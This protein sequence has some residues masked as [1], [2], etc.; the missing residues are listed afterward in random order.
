MNRG[1]L[2]DL[3]AFAVV[4]RESSFTRAATELRLSTSALSY[5]IKKLETRLGLVLLRRNSRSVSATEAGEKL[6]RR[7]GPA[8]AEIAGALDDAGQQRD[9]V[10]GTVRITATR[11][12]FE[13]VLRPILPGFGESHPEAT[14][15]VLVEY[16]FR[17]IVADRFDAG[18]RLGE[19]VEKDMIAVS[20]SP[21]L[22]MAV[23]ASPDYLA[24]QLAPETPVELT[25]HR[26]IN[27][28]MMASG[29]L[30][31]W[32]FERD[33][34]ALDVKVD[35]PLTFNEPALMLEAAVDGLG[36]AYVL[37]DQA[38][39][40]IADGRLVRLL[41]DW[42]PAFPGYFLYYPSRHQ[43]PPVL[44]ALIPTLRRWRVRME[45]NGG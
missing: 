12:A 3:A 38:S 32:E 9:R 40:L 44:A 33:G 37:E 13:T 35:G 24:R 15:E 19:K 23:V 42:T 18:I 20:V 10:S 29:S 22:R 11:H 45:T 27:Y 7:L 26:C 30:Y 31:P 41:A 21:E 36:V 1:D 14:V 39:P 34:R 43:I 28:R 17:D 6:L 2:D 16:G 4:A 25:R 5:T 8:L